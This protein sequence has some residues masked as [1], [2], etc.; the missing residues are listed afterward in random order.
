[1]F[2]QWALKKH[3]FLCIINE[4]NKFVFVTFDPI[5][6]LIHRACHS[7]TQAEFWPTQLTFG[8][9]VRSVFLKLESVVRVG[10]S[11]ESGLLF[12]SF[13]CVC[14][15]GWWA[16]VC[17]QEIQ[18]L[19][20]WEEMNAVLYLYSLCLTQSNLQTITVKIK[21]LSLSASL[22]ITVTSLVEGCVR[23]CDFITPICCT[24]VT[25]FFSQLCVC[26]FVKSLLVVFI[27]GWHKRNPCMCSEVA[28]SLHNGVLRY[29]SFRYQLCL[30]FIIEWFR[31]SLCVL[32]L[33]WTGH[34][35]KEFP[36]LLSENLG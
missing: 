26:V 30:S 9:A 19:G 22:E 17:S 35:S 4:W 2:P 11:L 3:T 29:G 34:P 27:C 24:A 36:C 7:V 25:V 8:T 1:M 31:S 28:F 20:P 10:S 14:V 15:C 5:C 18:S 33:W 32:V 23:G 6:H 13:V 12:L 21:Y 16:V